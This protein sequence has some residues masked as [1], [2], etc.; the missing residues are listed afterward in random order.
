MLIQADKVPHATSKRVY[1]IVKAGEPLV[2]CEALAVASWWQ[3]P[4]PVTGMPFTTLAS[5]LPVDA[6]DLDN[7]IS[8]AIHD[9]ETWM[10]PGWDNEDVKAL[11]ALRAWV[12]ERKAVCERESAPGV[13]AP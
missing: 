1:A 2:D 10:D 13:A 3:S 8:Y 5:Y 12:R 7:A 9:A 4:H 6:D 11:Q